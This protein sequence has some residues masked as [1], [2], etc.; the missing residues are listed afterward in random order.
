MARKS[1]R[2]SV[3]QFNEGLI[4]WL[5]VR[6][7]PKGI[8]VDAYETNRG[9]WSVADGSL[10][11]ALRSFVADR[12][13]AGD[14][15]CSV[16][17]RHEMTARILNLPSHHAAEI[18]GMVRLSA[19]EYVPYPAQELVI[20]QC[21]VEKRS[22]GS[23]RT[24]AVFAHR[25]VV[26]AHAAILRACGIE[27]EHIFVSTACLASAAAACSQGE[28]E[29]YALVHLAAGG[30]EVLVMNNGVIEYGRGVASA[31]DWSSLDDAGSDAAEELAVELRSS[32]AA[33]RRESEH[34]EPV[35]RVYVSSD[36][37]DPVS[38]ANALSA[39]TGYDCHPASFAE[40]LLDRRHPAM[41]SLP[42]V[43]FGAAM[44]AQ[45]RAS[46]EI[47]LVP[48]SILHARRSA[49][50]RNQLAKVG[51][52][53]AAIVFLA[54]AVYGQAAYTRS[55]YMGELQRRI[56]AVEPV[57]AGVEHKRAQLV[58]LQQHLDKRGSALELLARLTELAPR[59]G[60]AFTRFAF[61]HG[62]SLIIQGR[63][64]SQNYI[65][66]LA[67]SMREAGRERVPQFAR[68]RLGPTAPETEQ[69]TPVYQFEIVV[70]LTSPEPAEEVVSEP[71]E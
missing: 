34:G 67:D 56:A 69:N 33:Y 27:P 35:D 55:S 25:D 38:A 10:E 50:M 52:L 7:S 22:D 23:A 11:A 63:A 18:D 12:G 4:S 48:E 31:Q 58:R 8:E 66:E 21:I 5:R 64:E 16:L 20:D 59:T 17:P 49:R 13:I 42:L 39:S 36:Y 14:T 70:P 29:R 9:A 43:A 61:A 28:H 54:G 44:A 60:L 62:E 40:R 6:R 2:I 26:E 51:G 1:N 19:E 24:L 30:L 3:L 57:A 47:S 32:L 41:T 68:A 45:Q 15:V 37:A 71:G 53:A 46:I 65:F